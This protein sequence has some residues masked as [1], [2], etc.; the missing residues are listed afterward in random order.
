MG[1]SKKA[2]E[3]KKLRVRTEVITEIRPLKW[4]PEMVSYQWQVWQKLVVCSQPARKLSKQI[5]VFCSVNS[6]E[7]IQFWHKLIR[8]F[9][10][11]VCTHTGIHRNIHYLL[12]TAKGQFLWKYTEHTWLNVD[13][14][15]LINIIFLSESFLKNPKSQGNSGILKC[16]KPESISSNTENTSNV[17]MGALGARRRHWCFHNF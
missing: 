13:E 16:L 5:D 7:E 12:V 14:T 15:I 3:R 9:H 6:Q 4:V 10:P 11:N 8:K 17:A 2:G 1:R